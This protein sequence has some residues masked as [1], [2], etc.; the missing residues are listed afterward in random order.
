MLVPCSV[1]AAFGTAFGFAAAVRGE[2]T[3]ELRLGHLAVSVGVDLSPEGGG[4]LG[5]EWL[6]LGQDQIQHGVHLLAAHGAV[7]VGVH[8]GPRLLEGGALLVGRVR[9][10][11]VAQRR[12]QNGGRYVSVSQRA[13]RGGMALRLAL[14]RVGA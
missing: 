3:H 9:L 8:N 6:A 10:A 7:A 11:E 14:A 13:Q 12:L 1:A 5:R 4:L 2:H